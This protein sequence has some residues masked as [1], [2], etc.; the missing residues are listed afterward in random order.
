MF[1]I[2]MRTAASLD[3]ADFYAFSIVRFRREVARDYMDGVHA[4]LLRLVQYPESEPVFEGVKPRRPEL[5]YRSHRV[6]YGIDGRTMNIVR[7]L[8]SAMNV[9]GRLRN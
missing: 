1:E 8:H 6:L 3:I 5:I 2:E 4:T 7:I 9:P